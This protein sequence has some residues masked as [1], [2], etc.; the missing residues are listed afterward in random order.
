M[1]KIESE[2]SIETD[3]N[4]E[5]RTSPSSGNNISIETT[6][7]LRSLSMSTI[8]SESEVTLK[9]AFSSDISLNRFDEPITIRDLLQRR[10]YEKSRDGSIQMCSSSQSTIQSN[11]TTPRILIDNA[12]HYWQPPIYKY[13]PSKCELSDTK[14]V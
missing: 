1:K 13:S 8:S 5:N 9:R 14:S 10:K 7:M 12:S 11:D 6:T 4:N 2:L 3:F